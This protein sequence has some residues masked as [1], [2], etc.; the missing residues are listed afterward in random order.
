MQ[1]INISKYLALLRHHRQV[2]RNTQ[3]ITSIKTHNRRSSKMRGRGKYKHLN[4]GD[5]LPR[6]QK[7]G[8]KKVQTLII[9]IRYQEVA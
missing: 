7:T 6:P 1:H 9:F 2:K 8:T 5:R 3:C 4:E